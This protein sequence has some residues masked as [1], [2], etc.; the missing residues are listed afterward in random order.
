MNS[1][2]LEEKDF[3]SVYILCDL[4]LKTSYSVNQD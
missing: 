4:G 2:A 3:D 1:Y